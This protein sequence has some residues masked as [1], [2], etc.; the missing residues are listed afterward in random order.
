VNRI[1]HFLASINSALRQGTRGKIAL[2]AGLLILGMSAFALPASAQEYVSVVVQPGDTLG[3]IAA[4]HCADW[5]EVY[6]INR[7][8]IGPNP[9]RVEVGMVLTVPN[10]CGYAPTP[11]TPA[12]VPPGVYDRGSRNQATGTVNGPYYTV[13]WGDDL[14]AIGQRFGVAAASIASSNQLPNAASIQPGQ[15]LYIPGLGPREP[16][17]PAPTPTPQPPAPPQQRQFAHGECTISFSNS[18]PSH[19]APQ[20]GTSGVLGAGSY[21]ALEVANYSGVL[22]YHLAVGS[23]LPGWI[24]SSEVAYSTTG[25]CGL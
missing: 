6:N 23:T 9:N 13:A 24:S 4:R 16:A 12:P 2:L 22:W 17:Q 20:Q 21:M 3:K 10:R 25:N 19:F 18:A 7:Q 1:R 11:S 14:F 8:T 15:T 5:E